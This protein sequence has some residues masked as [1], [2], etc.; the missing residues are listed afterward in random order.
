VFDKPF[1][2]HAEF[3][4]GVPALR[5]LRSSLSYTYE[6]TPRGGLVRID[7][8]NRAARDAVHAFLR[9]QIREHGSGT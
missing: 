9:Y 8:G 4:P 7:T 2:T 6:A 1:R 5:R 3:P